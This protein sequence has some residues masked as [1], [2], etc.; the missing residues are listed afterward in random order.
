SIQ[1]SAFSHVNLSVYDIAGRKVATLIDGWRNAG[2]HE[3]VFDGSGLASG[4]YIAM[5]K[6]GDEQQ[7]QKITLLK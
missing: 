5:L 6:M 2:S 7:S 4:I 3:A 1:L